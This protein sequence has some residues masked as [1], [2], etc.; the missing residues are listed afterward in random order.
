MTMRH[1]IGYALLCA[2]GFAWWL[3]GLKLLGFKS[4]LRINAIL[5]GAGCI[6]ASGLFLLMESQG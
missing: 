5:I 3:Y 6:M 4:W 1:Y 2:P